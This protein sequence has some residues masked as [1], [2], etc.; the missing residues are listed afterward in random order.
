MRTVERLR[1]LL[2]K[3]LFKSLFMPQLYVSGDRFHYFPFTFWVKLLSSQVY[4]RSI[5]RV[6]FSCLPVVL[7]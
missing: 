7:T 5:N 3:F 2:G 1:D 6:K 4:A